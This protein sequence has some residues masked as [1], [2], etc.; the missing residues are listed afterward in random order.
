MPER[1]FSDWAFFP[2]GG[3]EEEATLEGAFFGESA[4]ALFSPDKKP[5][6]ENTESSFEG[7]RRRKENELSNHIKN[8]VISK[9]REFRH[10]TARTTHS[11]EKIE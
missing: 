2:L 4:R 11:K 9:R 3:G 8:D 6:S 1:I 10:G 5:A 7:D